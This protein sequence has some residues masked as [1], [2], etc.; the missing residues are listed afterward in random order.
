MRVI[1]G[2]SPLTGNLEYRQ[3]GKDGGNAIQ[4]LTYDWEAAGNLASRRD[5]NQGLVEEFRYDGLDRLVQSRRNGTVN[6]E[7]DYDPIGNIRRK[8]D[9]CTGAVPCYAYH[10]TR[11]HAVTTAGDRAYAYDANGNM[12]SRNGAAIA[13]SADNLPVSIAGDGGNS[14]QFSYSPDGRRWR[15][16]ARNGG[17]TETTIYAG[18]LFEKV[19][20]GGSTTWRHYVLAPGGTVVQLALRRWQRSGDAPAHARSRRQ[21]GPRPRCSRKRDRGRKLRGL[22]RSAPRPTGTGLP[23]AADLAKIAAVTRDGY[24]GHEMLDNLGLIHMNGRVYDPGLGRFLSADP[25]VTLPYD[26][27]GLNRYAYVLNNP[28][29]FTDP[30]ASTP[31]PCLATESGECVQITVIAASWAD[32]MRSHG[33]AHAGAV[34][35]A[36]ERDPCGQFGAGLACTMPGLAQSAASE[37]RPDRRQATRCGAVHGQPARCR[38]GIC[39]AHREH[40][41][42]LIARRPALRRRSRLPVLPRAGQRGRSC[43]RN[44]G[45]RRLPPGRRCRRHPQ[46]RPG[47]RREGRELRRAIVPGQRQVSGQWIGS[48][49]SS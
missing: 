10:A 22:R 42:Q 8:S 26:G 24:T 31:I 13:W 49:T 25:Y 5:L 2:F 14:S 28:L 19:T 36:L 46:A 33:G 23:T 4:D 9:V 21:H 17:A 38:A 15:Q 7:L 1:S 47:S 18:G 41:H 43:R 32:Y 29:A 35:S 16:V 11:R 40:R 12:T 48:G 6:L 27:Q 44:D 3:S 39:S 34:A 30:A 37:R 45:E 20:S